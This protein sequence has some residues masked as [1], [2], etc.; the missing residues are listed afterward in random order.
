LSK[1]TP[2]AR[3]EHEA[4]APVALAADEVAA[5]PAKDPDIAALIDKTLGEV[6][7]KALMKD[8]ASAGRLVAQAI[9]DAEESAA[10]SPD[11]DAGTPA[12]PA[13]HAAE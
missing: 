8:P 9:S 3:A 13:R 1:T 7:L 12:T 10:A 11:S 5:E 2:D 4:A 6:L